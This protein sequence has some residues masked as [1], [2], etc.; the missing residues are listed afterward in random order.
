MNHRYALSYTARRSI[1]LNKYLLAFIVGLLLIPAFSQRST[2]ATYY[3]VG[4]SGN[5]SDINHWVT[6]SG[7]SVNYTLVPTAFD[8]VV[9][10]QNS[11][12]ATG[13]VVTIN[14]ANYVCRNLSWQNVNYNPS[15]TNLSNFGLRIFGS[16]KLCSAMTFNVTGEISFE[17]STP[18]NSIYSAGHAFK[19][20]IT[21]NGDGGWDLLDSLDVSG[22][23]IY[24]KKG[25]L[26]TNNQS[27]QC[28]S[29]FSMYVSPRKIELGSSVV[30]ISGGWAAD[31]SQLQFDAATSTL[32]MTSGNATFENKGGMMSFYNVIFR[33]TNGMAVMTSPAHNPVFFNS[34]EFNCKAN[35]HGKFTFNQLSLLNK[36]YSLREND[37]ITIAQQLNTAGD[38]RASV[39]IRSTCDSVLAY[40]RKPLGGISIDYAILKDIAAITG[41][42]VANHSIDLQNNP[43]WVINSPA[44]QELYWVG[45]QG[46]WDNPAHWSYT[47]GGA[48]GAC[49]P[50]P[51]DNVHFDGNSFTAPGQIVALNDYNSF[52][53]NMDWSGSQ[54]TPTIYG[55]YPNTLNIFGSLTLIPNMVY[56]WSGYVYFLAQDSVNTIR[57]AGHTLENNVLFSGSKGYWNLMDDF[58]AGANIIFLV[59][60]NI[61]TLSHTVTCANLVSTYTYKRGLLLGS[62]T[63]NISGSHPGAWTVYK[64]RLNFDAGTSTINFT[65]AYG[66]MLNVGG[67][68]M[69][70][71]HVNFLHTSGMSSLGTVSLITTYSRVNFMNNGAINGDQIYDTL[72]LNNSY[73]KIASGSYQR[74]H[75]LLSNNGSCSLFTY[76]FTSDDYQPA[77]FSKGSG[78]VHLNYAM[79]QNIHADGGA[80]FIANHSIDLGNNNGWTISAVNGRDLYWVGGAGNWTDES[81][82]SLTSGGAGGECIPNPL[83]NVFFDSLSFNASSQTAYINTFYAF[84]HN[85]TWSAVQHTPVFAGMGSGNLLVFGSLAFCPGIQYMNEGTMIFKAN[86]GGNTIFTSGYTMLSP[87]IFN[88]NGGSWTLSSDF[89]SMMGVLLNQ[90]SLNTDGY[91]LSCKSFLSTSGLARSLSMSHSVFNLNANDA[92]AWFVVPNQFSLD[93]GTSTINITG[94]NGGI[95]TSGAGSLS[96]YNVFFKDSIACSDLRTVNA[97][98]AFNRVYFRSNANIWGNNSFDTLSFYPAKTYTLEA[99]IHQ[100]ILSKLDLSGNGCFPITLRSSIAGQQA[101]FYKSAGIVSAAYVE[102]HDQDATGGATFYAGNYSSDVSGNSGWIFNT[103]PGYVFGLPSEAL[104]CPGDTLNISTSNFIGGVSFI[105]QDGQNLSTYPATEAGDYYVHVTYADNCYLTDTLRLRVNEAAFA[106]ASPDTTVCPGAPVTLTASGPSDAIFIWSTGDTTASVTVAPQQNTAYTVNVHNY[107][108]IATETVSI[109]TFPVAV[110][111]A[112]SDTAVCPGSEVNLTATGI[113]GS[114]Y[115]W[116]PGVESQFLTLYPTSSGTYTVTVTDPHNCG[117]ATDAVYVEVYSLPWAQVVEDTSICEGSNLMLS[118]QGPAGSTWHWSDGSSHSQTFVSPVSDQ[119]FVVTATDAHQCGNATDTV[120]VHIIKLPHV[121][122]GTD[123]LVCPGSMLTLTAN[124]SDIDAIAWSDGS[125]QNSLTVY[126]SVPGVYTVQ[127]S[128][129]CGSNSDAVSVGIRPLPEVN[130]IVGN[131]FCNRQDGSIELFGA[132]Q[133]LW[134]NGESS[135]SLNHLASG[136]YSVTV[137]NEWCS[138]PMVIKVPATAGPEAHFTANADFLYE[139]QNFIFHDASEGAV[140]WYW[141]FGDGQQNT[142]A[143][144]VSH[145]YSETGVYEVSLI[146]SDRNACRDTAKMNVRMEFPDIFFMPNAF[147]P[148]DDGLNDEFG[149]SWR[150]PERISDFTMIIYNRWGEEI[151]E[152][153]DP[154]KGWDGRKNG[155]I[156]PDGVYTWLMFYKEDPGLKKEFTGQVSLLK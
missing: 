38:C 94:A 57:L 96:Y 137:S 108:G 2:A 33:D 13:Q 120:L 30:R 26:R 5:W 118:A 85:M 58:D 11:F 77:Y 132:N 104:I 115:Q 130:S 19:N 42:A 35:I 40:I 84:C 126:P 87:V 113:P 121:D 67:D 128:N 78:T 60:G 95:T 6:T 29:F 56:S 63:V 117:S 54:Y 34:V 39:F 53:H 114:T 10:D 69:N 136:N 141:N 22:Y 61:N 44:P 4:G 148:N 37:T 80:S 90:G 14:A 3:W 65:G 66:G 21:F 155:Q 144:E 8:D 50:T 62:S 88:G 86:D 146:V 76:I 48:G 99:G 123:T 71:W 153:N 18:H 51:I 46:S 103:G 24:Y 127:V 151:F 131:E 23:T 73:Y 52:C 107:C 105:W 154:A 7:G 125:H 59:K 25:H 133:Y 75:K 47:S 43:G 93:A 45:G 112:G 97:Q 149:P 55:S 110:A 129:Q 41:S 140:D 119:E 98:C 102:M 31:A 79:L 9:F 134:E 72:N 100:L 92:T 20:S 74:I 17:S 83:D 101:G 36:F 109:N 68:T 64:T 91:T 152:S 81:H 143:A 122:A 82:W 27:V 106:Q 135:S 28:G 32:I 124:G 156:A 1:S 49:V 150:L 145:L 12:T 142:G 139:G 138:V 16:L 147:T 116:N 111:N 70:F 15:F 89:T